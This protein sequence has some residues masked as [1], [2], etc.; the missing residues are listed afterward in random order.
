MKINSYILKWCLTT[1]E[2]MTGS[3]ICEKSSAAMAGINQE[4]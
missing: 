4:V 2:G 3:V 1:P